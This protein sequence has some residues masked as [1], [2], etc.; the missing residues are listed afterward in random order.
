[1]GRSSS[2]R[3][4]APCPVIVSPMPPLLS[5]LWLP[6]QRGLLT[7]RGSLAGG[8]RSGRTSLVTAPGHP[9][10]EEIGRSC[11]MAWEPHERRR[12]PMEERIVQADPVGDP[13]GYQREILTLLGGGA[14]VDVL[15]ATA[16]AIGERAKG[17]FEELLTR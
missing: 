8:G 1:M 16:L 13:Q 4:C 11:T 10:M 17:V 9:A 14:P 6:P 3:D 5:L 7:A 15:A 2:P 12:H